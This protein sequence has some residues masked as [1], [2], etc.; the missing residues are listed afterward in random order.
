MMTAHDY[1]NKY[2]D[3]KLR[4]RFFNAVIRWNNGNGTGGFW[5]KNVLQQ[6]HSQAEKDSEQKQRLSK[7]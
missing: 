1:A 3:E 6:L 5:T 2:V 4:T 7:L